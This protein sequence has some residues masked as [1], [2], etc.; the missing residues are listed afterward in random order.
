MQIIEK[1]KYIYLHLRFANLVS[2]E[3][4]NLVVTVH[5]TQVVYRVFSQIAR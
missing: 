1:K 3:T 5:P 4:D 2:F